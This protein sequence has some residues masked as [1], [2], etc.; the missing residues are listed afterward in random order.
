MDERKPR[1]SFSGF[2]FHPA[3]RYPLLL[4][5]LLFAAL[6]AAAQTTPRP[7]AVPAAGSFCVVRSQG[8][9]DDS[10]PRF[11]LDLGT[12]PKGEPEPLASADFQRKKLRSATDML[13]YMS[14]S[15]WELLHTTA[16]ASPLPSGVQARVEYQYVFR[17]KTQ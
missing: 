6:P 16:V 4:S 9:I 13:N 3:M 10:Q 7:P 15:G 14:D 5:A 1:G 8:V 12:L 2:L 11:T 17:R